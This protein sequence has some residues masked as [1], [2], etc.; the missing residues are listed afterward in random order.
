[1]KTIKHW[2]AFL[3]VAIMVSLGLSAC[4]K[5]DV[6]KEVATNEGGIEK[7]VLNYQGTNSFVTY[8]E[9]AED[10][11]YLGPIK[12]YYLGSI[13][14][15]P[16]DLQSLATG[17]VDFATA[18][19][20]AIIKL[21]AS[22]VDIVSVVAS[23]GSDENTAIGFYVPENSPIKSA[24]D[25]IGKKIS[26]NTL[27]AHAEFVI[28]DYL[29]RGGLTKAEIDQVELTAL[30]PVNSEQALRGGQV[31]VAQLQGILKDKAFERGGLR[32]LF[33]DIELYGNFTAG[34]YTFTRKFLKENPN[35]V[36]KFV[37]GTARA[38]E[39]ARTTPREEVIARYTDIINKRARNEDVRIVQFWK[40]TG[41]AD[42]GG[43]VT[44]IQYQQWIDW[45]VKDGQ[46]APNKI[47]ASDLYDNSFNPYYVSEKKQ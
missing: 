28:K 11:G 44:E 23:Y 45:L 42:K 33:T 19:N 13:I 18:F 9:L 8:P 24:R 4:S 5:E 15:G 27:G 35:T 36:R 40:S 31:D 43:V 1:M 2:L 21:A 3:A 25:L 14:G 22:G 37:E 17:D 6:N 10:L 32:A 7:L 34:N 39:W 30:P 41:I 46:L 12:M 16:Q 26:V 29:S 47:K 38:I 20:G